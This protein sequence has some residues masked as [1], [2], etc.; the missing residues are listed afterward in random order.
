KK[1]SRPHQKAIVLTLAEI[2]EEPF[3]GKP[4]TRELTGK[5]SFRVGVYRIIY[6]V[7]KKDK[8]I[9]ILTAGH[10]ATIYE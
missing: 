5:F 4:L 10:R 2:K 1:I 3:L 8:V 6:K 7:N 9:E